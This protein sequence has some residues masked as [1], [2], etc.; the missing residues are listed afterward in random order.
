MKLA[1]INVGSSIASELAVAQHSLDLVVLEEAKSAA[2]GNIAIMESENKTYSNDMSDNF[3]KQM[4]F[5]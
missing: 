4:V 5:G 1:D 3:A 2:N